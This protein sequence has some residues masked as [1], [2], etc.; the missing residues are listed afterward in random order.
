MIP[1]KK[2]A[3]FK[4]SVD[5]VQVNPVIK[6]N[7]DFDD[8]PEEDEKP[9]KQNGHSPLTNGIAKLNKNINGAEDV[10]DEEDFVPVNIIQ[11]VDWE[12]VNYKVQNF[13]VEDE[14]TGLA[15]SDEYIVAQFFMEPEIHVFNRENFTLLH[16]LTGHDYG[17]QAVQILDHI[18]YSGSKDFTLK[19]WDLKSG[20]MIQSVQ[21]HRD[22]IQCI[23]VKKIYMP[24]L[25][26][27]IMALASGGSADH[28]INLYSTQE[29]GKF[30]KRFSLQGHSG[31]VTCIEIT[32]TMVISGGKDSR[33]KLWDLSTGD[34]LQTLEQ[35]AEI[36]SLS[37]YPL[38]QGYCVFGDG[39]SKMSL[40]D[41][42]T[43]TTIHMMPNTLIG[44]GKYMRSSKY[45][46]KNVDN[47]HVCD[48][49]YMISAS[50]GSKFVKIW[51]IEKYDECVMKTDVTELQI[52]RDHSDYLSV[53][54]VH[55]NTIISSCGDGKIFLHTF[56]EG[57]QH[58][59]MLRNYER[60]SVAA[61]FQGT[62]GLAPSVDKC[63]VVC[64]GKLCKVGKTGL[65]RSSSSF[66]V[67]FSLSKST[68][69]SA[70]G[71]LFVPQTITEEDSEE[72]DSSAE[73]VI[74][75]VT[76]SDQEDDFSD[77]DEEW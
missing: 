24:A 45:H 57:E 41:L 14:V 74:E 8:L 7:H 22:Y 43:G 23:C 50:S 18:L 73:F 56:P 20:K 66:Q 55:K 2:S 9:V 37:L 35:D 30:K 76:D 33:I 29:S 5:D 54:S 6:Y 68:T 53:I 65:A 10:S 64:E 72:D 52:L 71:R 26:E 39:E 40:L 59:D 1:L 61:V 46:D 49:G 25:G 47:F 4:I 19:S 28:M 13:E 48:N 27:E 60:N 51:K 34:L 69:A 67:N 63:T 3:S 75:Y 70:V 21:D 12:S 32:E 17:G 38:K 11:G 15:V 42:S 44:T 16:R 31:W 58:Y 77:G 62:Q 36:T